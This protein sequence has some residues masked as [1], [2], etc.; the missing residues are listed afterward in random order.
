MLDLHADGKV[1][2]SVS[3]IPWP[4]CDIFGHVRNFLHNIFPYRSFR[5]FNSAILSI[6]TISSKLQLAPD[7][8]L[9]LWVTMTELCRLERGPSSNLFTRT[10]LRICNFRQMA[11]T[12]SQH[13]KILQRSL[14]I[15]NP[16]KCWRHTKL[17]AHAIL[18][19]YLPS[20]TM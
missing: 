16:Y 14:W 15:P 8:L 2:F 5:V 13:L 10:T 1:W 18:Q 20:T 3:A 12:L 11:R 9:V 6:W 4:W 17:S 19:P 7:S